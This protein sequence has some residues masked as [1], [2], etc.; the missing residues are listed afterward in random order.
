[1]DSIELAEWMKARDVGKRLEDYVRSAMVNGGNYEA[2]RGLETDR[3]ATVNILL[4]TGDVVTMVKAE[5]FGEE[6]D[7]TQTQL[8]EAKAEIKKLEKEVKRLTAQ[9]EKKVAKKKAKVIER[10]T[11]EPPLEA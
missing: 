8:E 5:T 11:S 7:V 1:M 2:L 3:I 6:L 10:V 4:G 9:A